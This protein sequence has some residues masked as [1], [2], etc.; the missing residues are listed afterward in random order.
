MQHTAAYKLS[1]LFQVSHLI[2]NCMDSTLKYSN[3]YFINI[4]PKSQTA[5]LFKGNWMDSTQCVESLCGNFQRL[6]VYMVQQYETLGLLASLKKKAWSRLSRGCRT[7]YSV[8]YNCEILFTLCAFTILMNNLGVSA[9]QRNYWN[10]N[11]FCTFKILFTHNRHSLEALI[12]LDITLRDLN[13]AS[14]YHL[15][16]PTVMHYSTVWL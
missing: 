10:F 11:F 12:L 8:Q 7:E 6:W 15:F 9:F 4:P 13:A 5:V 1:F 3:L 2:I 14:H 16:S